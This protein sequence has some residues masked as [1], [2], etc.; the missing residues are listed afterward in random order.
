ML[1]VGRH[2]SPFFTIPTFW[3]IVD[4]K[5]NPTNALTYSPG[6]QQTAAELQHWLVYDKNPAL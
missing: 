5:L 6:G 3:T 1:C 4:F 2:L